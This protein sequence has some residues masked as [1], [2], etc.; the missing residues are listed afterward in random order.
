[1]ATSPHKWQKWSVPLLMGLN[2]LFL[3]FMLW[4]QFAP[5][6]GPE[7]GPR[8]NEKSI[9]N[10]LVKELEL[11]ETQSAEYEALIKDHQMRNRASHQN[12]RRL[13][14]Q[15]IDLMGVANKEDQIDLIA[16]EIGETHADLIRSNAEHFAELRE[17]LTPEQQAKLAGLLKEVMGKMGRQMPP[18]GR[19][20]PPPRR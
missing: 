19:R 7:K 2:I 16:Q 11:N 3:C 12:L 4:Q 13:M 9:Q 15:Q 1:M 20:P 5:Q 17:I 14:D 6:D 10:L 8:Q 18:G